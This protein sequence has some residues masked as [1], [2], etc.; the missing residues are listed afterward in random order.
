L[1]SLE[2]RIER[3][4]APVLYELRRRVLRGNDPESNVI[5]TRDDDPTTRHFAGYAGDRVVVS[6]S[7]YLATAPVN[8]ELRSYQLRFM[9]VDFDVQGGGYGTAVMA[10][11]EAALRALG[12]E[13]IWA[14]ARDTALGFYRATGWTVVPG[15]EHVSG[16]TR[17]PH[18]VVVRRLAEGPTTTS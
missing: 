6:A 11:A 15:S 2:L 18:S 9:A 5:D 8:P 17:L 10:T 12:A 7:F 13:Q 1:S 4:S 14:N 3:V 16:E